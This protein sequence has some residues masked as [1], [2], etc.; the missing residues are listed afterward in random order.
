VLAG[1]HTNDPSDLVVA[2]VVVGLV[3][4]IVGATSGL[5]ALW[6]TF[7]E[8]PHL[9]VVFTLHGFYVPSEDGDKL[10]STTASV[11]MTNYGL[12]TAFVDAVEFCA[13]PPWHSRLPILKRVPFHWR[14]RRPFRWLGLGVVTMH[15]LP[16]HDVEL[17]LRI[18]P[19]Q[20]LG[21]DVDVDADGI[22]K[23]KNE[24][25]WLVVQTGLRYYCVKVFDYR[26]Q[27]PG[28]S[29]DGGNRNG[30]PGK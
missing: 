20:A 16:L 19:G 17:P 14:R 21:T 22:D 29:P 8:G 18:E 7:R 30:E 26:R 1:A 11:K 10:I 5:V 13:K 9:D 27:L 6:R 28:E 12:G 25:P 24:T 2:G 4:G 15:T 23:L 3:A